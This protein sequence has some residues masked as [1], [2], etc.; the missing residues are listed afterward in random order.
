MGLSKAAHNHARNEVHKWLNRDEIMWRQRAKA[1]WLREGDQNSKFFHSKA[2]HRKRKNF[3][4][5]LQN[6]AREWKVG[7]ERD[8]LIVEYFR[9]IFS[10]SSQREMSDFLGDLVGKVTGEMNEELTKLYTE[11]EVSQFLSLFWMCYTLV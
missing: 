8:Q 9:N 4:D 11:S 6:D 1:L 10:A 7:E 2:S 5:K 3:I